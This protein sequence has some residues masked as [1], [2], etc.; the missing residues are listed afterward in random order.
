[1]CTA[2]AHLEVVALLGSV[3]RKIIPDSQVEDE[4]GFWETRNFEELRDEFTDM[5]VG[6][7]LIADRLRHKNNLSLR[8][9]KEVG[10]LGFLS[11]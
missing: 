8:L 6:L 7:D 5:T 3:K 9:K 4:S 2:K 10:L 1:M 11:G